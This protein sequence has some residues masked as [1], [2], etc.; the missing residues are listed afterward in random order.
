MWRAASAQWLCSAFGLYISAAETQARYASADLLW[1]VGAGL[2]YWQARLW[3][4]TSRGEMHDD[5][6]VFAARDFGSR[7]TL[8]C[9]IVLT[10]LAYFIRLPTL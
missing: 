2:L 7:L 4:K 9:M 5:P 3:I 8:V 10:L 6:I 1:L